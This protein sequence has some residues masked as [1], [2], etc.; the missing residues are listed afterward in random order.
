MNRFLAFPKCLSDLP[1]S[2][3]ASRKYPEVRV[4]Q[5]LV[6]LA[7]ALTAPSPPTPR[8]IPQYLSLS[9]QTCPKLVVNQSLPRAQVT[10]HP[11]GGLLVLFLSY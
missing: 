10:V 7:M 2:L 5:S 9:G 4:S 11:G 3:S 8:H 6:A 1:L